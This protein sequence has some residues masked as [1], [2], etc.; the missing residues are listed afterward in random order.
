MARRSAPF[1]PGEHKPNRVTIFAR[2]M[3]LGLVQ[4]LRD[5]RNQIGRV[6]YPDRKPDSRIENAYFFA[7][8][9]RNAGVGRA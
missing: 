6:F 4:R 8:V 2:L 9:Y 3:Q 7:V 5:V 1:N